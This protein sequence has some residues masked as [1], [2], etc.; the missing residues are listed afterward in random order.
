MPIS[1]RAAKL[2]PMAIQRRHETVAG[3]GWQAEVLHDLRTPLSVV[4]LQAQ[5][6]RR[7]PSASAAAA[8]TPSELALRVDRIERAVAQ[9]AGMLDELQDIQWSDA[10]PPALRRERTD[11][12]ELV[13]RIAENHAEQSPEHR[14][15]V[16]AEETPLHGNWDAARLERA[17]GNLVGN[18]VKYSPG[19]G[20][21]VVEIWRERFP[22]GDHAAVAVRDP[23]IG[24]PEA[25]LPHIFKRFYRGGNA[26]GR[27]SGAGVGLAGVQSIIE[28]HGGTVTVDSREGHGTTFLLWL[29]VATAVPCRK[30]R[31]EPRE[32]HPWE[33]RGP[34][35]RPGCA[36]RGAHR[37]DSDG[38]ARGDGRPSV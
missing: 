5:L 8:A 1:H 6:L 24:I 21:V 14:I 30:D 11:V 36:V 12:V 15:S 38:P 27:F 34:E 10:T 4:R 19:G 32:Q 29:S 28:Q 2:T 31:Q 23:G 22:A 3:S 33:T 9:M 26:V 25:D 17:I 16:H 13:R 7:L 20:E 18:A 35:P 37:P